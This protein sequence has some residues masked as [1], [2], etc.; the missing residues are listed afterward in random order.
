MKGFY[1]FLKFFK[2]FVVAFIVL[3]IT[4]TLPNN[5]SE[6]D[7]LSII[8]I[9][10]ISVFIISLLFGLTEY[11]TS[12]AFS[13]N[14]DNEYAYFKYA[15][16]QTI[17]VEHSKVKRVS[18]TQNRYVFELHDNTKVCLLRK[19]AIWGGDQQIYNTIKMLY[20]ERVWG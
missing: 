20:N 5:I 10:T 9:V 1:S 12:M 19:A 6:R 16:G 15:S 11:Y 8:L 17:I 4:I 18:C 13:F 3:I 7:Y 14:W 2:W